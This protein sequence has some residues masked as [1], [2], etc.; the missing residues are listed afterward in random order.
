MN[1]HILALT[2]LALGFVLLP[3]C[4]KP[5]VS[6]PAKITPEPAP[7]H[8]LEW[9]ISLPWGEGNA[10][11]IGE[12][13][14]FSGPLALTAD[15]RGGLF[16]ADPYAGTLRHAD[17]TLRVTTLAG[18][19][20]VGAFRDGQGSEA[21]FHGPAG[22]AA[23]P[24]GTLYVADQQNNAIRKIT[25]EGRVS[26]LA[27][28]PGKSGHEE[29]PGLTALFN[30]PSSIV[31]DRQNRL[32]VADHFNSALRIVAMDGQ[33]STWIART[34]DD[35]KPGTHSFPGI[36]HLALSP[37]GA[38]IAAGDWGVSRIQNETA[39]LLI[40]PSETGLH[41]ISGLA[42][43]S[44]GVIH[45]SDAS[46]NLIFLLKPDGSLQAVAGQR[47]HE[48]PSGQ[49]GPADTARLEEPGSLAF[50]REGRLFAANRA[51]SIQ[52]ILP[53]GSVRNAMGLARW[54]RK[55]GLAEDQVM[56]SSADRAVADTRGHIFV[57]A[58]LDGEI[59]QFN[60]EGRRVRQFGQSTELGTSD[61]ARHVDGKPEEAR[62]HYPQDLA[63]GRNGE[64]FV[65][66]GGSGTIRRIAPDGAVSTLAGG[67]STSHRKDGSFREAL[68]FRPYRLAF[69]GRN[70]LYV[71]DNS[72]YIG[73]GPVPPIV[74][75]LDLDSAQVS[76]VRIAEVSDEDGLFSSRDVFQDLAVGPEG[77][78]WLL[79]RSGAV[80][81]W[82]QGEALK[83]IFVPPHRPANPDVLRD[84]EGKLVENSLI[85]STNP[86]EG[87]E[88]LAVDLR[89]NLYLSNGSADLILRVDPS[90]NVD[91][92]AGT[93]GIR[94]NVPGPLPSSLE[95]PEGLSIT[96][97]GDLLITLMYSG[98]ARIRAPH[99]VQGTRIRKP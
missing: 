80:Y 16:I 3:A 20:G 63:W 10:D 43:R 1:R 13:A 27:G 66:D 17:A 31:L 85:R 9:I 39:T 28:Q 24:D 65:A 38:L 93:P 57:L 52:E 72:P 73:G 51:M 70:K 37:D 56:P 90:G 55:A 76:S 46:Q 7:T 11:G 69:D 23:A 59:H 32:W 42:V 19:A 96:P 48:H 15:P 88:H 79:G 25:P 36:S 44:D 75:C 64:L 95:Y 62:F 84:A 83:P 45:I 87:L 58:R 68:F 50:D 8:Q 41:Q 6:P 22:L 35:P 18:Q 97:N 34:N 21:Q 67:F 94:G 47:S 40:E 81:G 12:A 4:R 30:W 86:Y 26:T 74:R 78:L 92:I 89:G 5:A 71:L 29:G 61:L 2:G 60:A 54:Y 99:L 98:V 53:G 82:R 49:E 14:R 33:V 77:R 91:V